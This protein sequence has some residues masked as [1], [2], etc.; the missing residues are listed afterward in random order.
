MKCNCLLVQICYFLKSSLYHIDEESKRT[1]NLPMMGTT[2]TLSGYEGMTISLTDITDGVIA[3]AP[4]L[5]AH[6]LIH[7]WQGGLKFDGVTAWINATDI[8]GE[9]LI[10]NKPESL[11]MVSLLLFI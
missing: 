3:S 5:K 6:G 8:D 9:C 10:S 7:K 1:L 2:E 11:Q 4:L